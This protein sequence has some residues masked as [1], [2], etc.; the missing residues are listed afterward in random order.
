MPSL[1]IIPISSPRSPHESALVIM[2]KS[3]LFKIAHERSAKFRL[4]I[5]LRNR[6]YQAA[7][8]RNS[9]CHQ[10]SEIMT[11]TRRVAESQGDQ[12]IAFNWYHSKLVPTSSPRSTRLSRRR[13][14]SKSRRVHW[15]PIRS[16]VN[17]TRS[18]F[19]LVAMVG[20]V[21]AMAQS[22]AFPISFRINGLCFR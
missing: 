21:V 19:H 11:Q 9:V 12:R 20:Q 16:V 4:K 14:L 1:L 18:S 6:A 13:R 22:D 7:T 8:T 5:Y 15:G 17:L 3:A 2:S 10:S